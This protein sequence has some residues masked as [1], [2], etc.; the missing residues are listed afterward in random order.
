MSRHQCHHHI[1]RWHQHCP[2]FV[3]PWHPSLATL[4]P[5]DAL[6]EKGRCRANVLRRHLR[7]RRQ[8]TATISS[9]S[10]LPI[11]QRQL[12][13]LRRIYVEYD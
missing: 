1:Q 7:H 9:G 2:G 11:L 3:D 10:F 8:H 12:G 5:E 6:E 4:G 13:V